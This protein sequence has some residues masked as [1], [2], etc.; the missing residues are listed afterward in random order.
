[1]DKK[2]LFKLGFKGPIE[3]IKDIKPFI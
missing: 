2:T 3:S 1:M